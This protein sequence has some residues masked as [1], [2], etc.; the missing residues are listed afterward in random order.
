MLEHLITE[1]TEKLELPLNLEKDAKGYMTLSLNEDLTLFF[2]DL[3]PGFTCKSLIGALP[4]ESSLETLYILLMKANF[5]GQGTKGAVIGL[6]E[7]LQNI[8]FTLSIPEELT[9]RHFKDR[10]EDFVNYLNYWKKRIVQD[11][12]WK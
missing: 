5:L 6:D 12:D 4:K 9:Y 3:N 2:K 1:L 10:V 7:N 8:T 11:K